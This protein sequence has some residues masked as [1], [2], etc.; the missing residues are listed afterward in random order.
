VSVAAEAIFRDLVRRRTL[1][2]KTDASAIRFSSHSAGTRVGTQGATPNPSFV[3]ALHFKRQLDVSSHL[4]VSLSS[5]DVETY[6]LVV[7]TD[8]STR[9]EVLCEFASGRDG[10]HSVD[11]EKKFVVLSQYCQ[12]ALRDKVVFRDGRYERSSLNTLLS[13]LIDAC[14][15]LL[16][17]LLES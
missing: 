6:D 15:G 12:G 4:S 16:T 11:I 9:S 13:A 3:E 8:E 7:C 14:T 5:A 1:G 10:R 17:S 2:Q